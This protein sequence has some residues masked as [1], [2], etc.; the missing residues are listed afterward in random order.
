MLES[1][2]VAII[3][4]DGTGRLTSKNERSAQLLRLPETSWKVYFEGYVAAEDK[5]AFR[6][7]WSACRS[8]PGVH[9]RDLRIV[10]DKGETGFA[11]LSCRWLPA[12]EELWIGIVEIEDLKQ[13]EQ[14]ADEDARRHRMLLRETNHRTKNMLQVIR[15][16][17]ELKLRAAEADETRRVIQGLYTQVVALQGAVGA[18][19]L[20]ANADR[21]DVVALISELIHHLRA[22]SVPDID[23]T[24]SWDRSSL[25]LSAARGTSLGLAVS[26]LTFNAME[27]AF[28]GRENGTVEIS[29]D[30]LP[31]GQIAASVRD[32]GIGFDPS[33]AGPG[34]LGIIIVRD[35]VQNHLN[36]SIEWI[37]KDP[38]TDARIVFPPETSE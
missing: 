10:A 34:S 13:S 27:H 30:T 38:G 24:T 14:R 2:P 28:E 26:E 20:G 18:L 1:V 29:L 37:G 22:G 17:L 31:D 21:I 33:S 12:S 35:L 7:L 9:V 15:S 23:I 4:I 36:G 8:D 16:S 19:S 25:V 5:Q 11:R 3:T 32:D 6:D